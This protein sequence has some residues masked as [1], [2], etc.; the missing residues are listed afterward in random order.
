MV[1]RIYVLYNKLSARYGDV[2]SF[3]T[4]AMAVR[5]ISQVLQK[6]GFADE[7][8]LYKV[9]QIDVETGE[10]VANAPA[11]VPLEV[12]ESAVPIDSIEKSM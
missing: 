11:L 12:V 4:D 10:C 5:T 3:P 1:N 7:F 6:Q 9:G 2:T 8:A